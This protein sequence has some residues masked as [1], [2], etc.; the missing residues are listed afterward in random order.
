M[1]VQLDDILKL[2]E[3][4]KPCVELTSLS[5]SLSFA[6][7]SDAKQCDALGQK[8]ANDV[9]LLIGHHPTLKRLVLESFDDLLVGYLDKYRLPTS[10]E[11]LVLYH[12][13]LMC[14]VDLEHGTDA[15]TTSHIRDL[16]ISNFFYFVCP[17]DI[18]RYLKFVESQA[19]TLV[20]LHINLSRCVHQ[21]TVDRLKHMAKRLAKS[22]KLQHFTYHV[23]NAHA[24]LEILLDVL[25]LIESLKSYNLSSDS[26]LCDRDFLQ[27]LQ[28]A[29]KKICIGRKGLLDFAKVILY[30]GGREFQDGI[31]IVE[32]EKLSEVLGC[33]C[34]LL[35]GYDSECD[36]DENFEDDIPISEYEEVCDV[37]MLDVDMLDVDIVC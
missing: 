18:E 13:S 14:V 28:L 2:D 1:T 33:Q 35:D 9:S 36:M 5:L 20:S 15:S 23:Q 30:V 34:H 6:S 25:P 31:P 7:L 21:P 11:T 32:Y 26:C 29:M 17:S 10:L 8:L 37:D 16:T 4:L 27:S 22:N 12:T 19:E 24:I 3:I